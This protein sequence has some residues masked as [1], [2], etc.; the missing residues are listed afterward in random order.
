MKRIS[1]SLDLSGVRIALHA[2]PPE[3]RSAI[4]YTVLLTPLTACQPYSFES[5]EN[6]SEHSD[7]ANNNGVPS[8]DSP[9]RCRINERRGTSLR[10]CKP[11]LTAPGCSGALRCENRNATAAAVARELVLD[12]VLRKF[13]Q[14]RARS[15]FSSREQLEDKKGTREVRS[16]VP[17]QLITDPDQPALR[18]GRRCRTRSR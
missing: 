1:F 17:M 7:R 5:L 8:Y 13:L 18:S 3:H 10:R 4:S 9:A 15:E 11:R 2:A 6:L 12:H 14:Q 16:R